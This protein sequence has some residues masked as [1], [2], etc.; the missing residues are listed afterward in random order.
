M[1][2]GWSPPP[3]ITLYYLLRVNAKE[4]VFIFSQPWHLQ[5]V[6][7]RFAIPD[8]RIHKCT[9]WSSWT[10]HILKI[11]TDLNIFGSKLIQSFFPP[12]KAY[13]SERERE[14]ERGDP[15]SCFTCHMSAVARALTR[16]QGHN[17]VFLRNQWLGQLPLPFRICR[18]QSKGLN[19][20]TMIWNAEL[21]T[22]SNLS[23]NSIFHWAFGSALISV[24]P[25]ITVL[26]IL[27]FCKISRRLFAFSIHFPPKEEQK[28]THV[29][30]KLWV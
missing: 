15:I 30:L 26:I 3:C 7:H 11:F 17:P 22:C 1:P 6:V 24:N 4:V 25:E 23:L 20:S 27:P 29:L 19:P 13:L 18:S 12:L 28:M 10:M 2:S 5:A 14:K 16:S 21:N 8:L 9:S